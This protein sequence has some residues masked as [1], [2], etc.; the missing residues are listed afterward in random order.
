MGDLPYP[1]SACFHRPQRQPLLR[2]CPLSIPHCIALPHTR[3]GVHALALLY[4][5]L[6]SARTVRRTRKVPC[7]PL[8]VLR[9]FAIRNQCEGARSSR[10]L[11]GVRRGAAPMLP[12]AAAP[13]QLFLSPLS[14]FVFRI[15]HF[16]K[17]SGG[18]W[19]GCHPRAGEP[20]GHCL[21]ETTC[22]RPAAATRKPRG[23]QLQ[24]LGKSPNLA[25]VKVAVSALPPLS[26]S[27]HRSTPPG[28][29]PNG[30]A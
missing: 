6:I 7:P 14:S 18:F 11:K 25:P 23:Q 16:G 24:L 2:H 15:S 28:G 1:P 3:F 4:L 19:L 22:Q 10:S 29:T 13:L 9:I 5:S 27:E 26:P 30:M 17:S 21:Q 12:C 8:C 20:L